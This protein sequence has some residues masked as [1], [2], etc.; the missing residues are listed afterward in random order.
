MPNKSPRHLVAPGIEAGKIH[1]SVRKMTLL[2][3]ITSSYKCNLKFI[4]RTLFFHPL[5][6]R[7][8]ILQRWYDRQKRHHGV[9]KDPSDRNYRN[10]SSSFRLVPTLT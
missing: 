3:E 5:H 1:I 10:T 4:L 8:T 7:G 6:I 2:L 9:L